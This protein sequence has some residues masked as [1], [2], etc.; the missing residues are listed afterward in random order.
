V[1]P[2]RK[3]EAFQQ[4]K[5]RIGLIALGAFADG[6]LF[7]EHAF[8]LRLIHDGVDLFHSCESPVVFQGREK[9]DIG[10]RE[11]AFHFFEA[12]RSSEAVYLKE[13]WHT[14]E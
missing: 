14:N 4:E 10:E 3:E 11:V 7:H 6:I 9:G 8:D 1:K 12:H 2:S 13:I 5:W